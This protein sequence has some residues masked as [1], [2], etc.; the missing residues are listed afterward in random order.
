MPCLLED[1]KPY[2]RSLLWRV[3]DSYFKGRG[4]GAW[5]DGEVP[6]YQTNNAGIATE[7]AEFL[8]RLVQSLQTEGTLQ[9]GAT[10]DV[11]VLE[12]GAG[13]GH[14]AANFCTALE[15]RLGE[16]GRAVLGRLR[17]VYSDYAE[18]SVREALVTPHLQSWV[19]RGIVLPALYDLHDPGRLTLLDTEHTAAPICLVIASYVCD[20]M[21][22]KLLQR[23]AGQWREQVVQ[24]TAIH[25]PEDADPVA[26]LDRVLARAIG[27]A[28]LPEVDSTFEW[29]DVD[30]ASVLPG[31]L[32][33][34]LLELA[35][36]G[37]GDVSL[38]YPYPF[39]DFLAGNGPI[40]LTGGAVA[41]HDYGPVSPE[42][43]QG[44]QDKRPSTYGNSLSHEVAFPLFDAFATLAS[45]RLVRTHDALAA[46]QT[47]M[48][49]RDVDFS[50]DLAT[51]FA[52]I[53]QDQ[54][55]GA[56]LVDFG[57]AAR[58]LVEQDQ[59]AIAARFY[60]RALRLDPGNCELIAKLADAC[61]EAGH[62]DVAKQS[63]LQ[64]LELDP[65]RKHDFEFQMGRVCAQ[66]DENDAAIHWY[67]RSLTREDHAVT[68]VNLGVVYETQGKFGQAYTEF[69]RAQGLD[70]NYQ[71]AADCLDRIKDAWWQLTMQAFEP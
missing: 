25:E 63:L 4:L 51:A 62:P 11:W 38:A 9:P 33:A 35:T 3:H 23:V 2:D 61:I 29:R 27:T 13:I 5:S 43:M 50:A 49:R 44:V 42:R 39:M 17:Y 24:V 10:D 66:L 68:H 18:R 22:C 40:L 12:V 6:W 55:R 7:T 16:P 19:Q 69:R 65:D 31:G 59:H 30:L 45:W 46:L 70:P 26:A 56:D 15:Q 54:T 1:W 8:I 47:A 52:R 48:L 21:P 28:G 57:S 14:F 60:Q 53:W 36:A 71:R 41:I 67:S 37:L 20:V 58:V 64:G 34:P 32:H